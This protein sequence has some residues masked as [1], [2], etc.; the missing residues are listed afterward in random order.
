LNVE[1]FPAQNMILLSHPTGNQFVRHAALALAE[2][3]RL[4]EF[5]TCVSWDPESFVNR[6]LPARVRAE[7]GRRAFPPVVRRAIRCHPWREAGRMFS[8]VTNTGWLVRHETGPCSVDAVFQ[9]LDRRVARRLHDRPEGVTGIY[10]YEDGAR[11]SFLAGRELGMERLYDLP[12]GYWRA[13]QKMFAEEA[14]R[15]PEWAATLTGTLDSPAKLERKDEELKLASVVIAASGFTRRTLEEYPGLTAP[16]RV[17]PYG[18]PPVNPAPKEPHPAGPLRVLYVGSLTQR[19][20]LSYFFAACDRLGRSAEVTVIGRKV[21]PECRALDNAL[22]RCR[23]IPSLPHA[24]VLE[25]MRRH[26]VLVF[27]SLFEGFGLVILEAMAQGLPVI[28]TPH[29]AG[30]EVIADGADGF[31]VPIR[32]A[33]AIAAKLELLASDRRLLHEMGE[34]ARRKAATLGWEHYRQGILELARTDR[35]PASRARGAAVVSS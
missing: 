33:D 13:A 14:G 22:A 19:K 7:L 31:L 24:E 2:A 16:V 27:P 5:W 8:Q 6:L 35:E 20:G 18:A 34:A 17:V 10:A 9:S 3:G 12:I 15:A 1:R 23:W 28:T 30:P 21:A 11:D 29:T 4:A 25:Q 26:D 32:S